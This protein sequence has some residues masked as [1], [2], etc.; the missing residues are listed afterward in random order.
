[1]IE[2]LEQKTYDKNIDSYEGLV[3][4]QQIK[5]QIPAREV[6]ESVINSRKTI[7]DILDGKDK[8]IMFIAGPCSI[9]NHDEAI[10]YAILLKE[11]SKKYKDKLFT[12][13]RAY[14]EKPRTRTGWEG[15]VYDP[16]LNSSYNIDEGLKLSRDILVRM[17]EI[18]LP[19]ITEF[20][21]TITPQYID[22]LLSIA[23][24]G[25][26]TTESQ[27]HRN[28][29]SG[30][31]MP[32]GFKN[33]TSGDI[34]TAIDSM[35]ASLYPHS[36]LGITKEGQACKVKTKGNNY[37][38]LILRGGNGQP[39][40]KPELV[41]AAINKL[42]KAG[43]K[44]PINKSIIIDCSHANSGKNYEKQREVGIEVLKQINN[45]NKH[46]KALMFE[47]NIH[48][49]NQPMN[50]PLKYGTS[51]TDGCIGWQETCELMKEFYTDL[52]N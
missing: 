17:A 50:F 32:V 8:R 13:M 42:E 37:T 40:Y 47:S 4:P 27:I 24:I 26:R 51:I 22:D 10:E 19:S 49:G 14:F 41:N 21:S 28:L 43:E 9:H 5:N 45:G 44:Y 29:V 11:E 31:S 38:H 18:N 35:I 1:M 15:F 36:F 6:Y 3:T 52:K 25:A 34:D 48:E 23:T 7:E 20:L 2:T 39:N 16:E 46:I 12:I 30:L 33:S